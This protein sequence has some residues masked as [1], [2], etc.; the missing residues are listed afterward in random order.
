MFSIQWPANIYEEHLGSVI[1]A[2][3]ILLLFLFF[4]KVFVKALTRLLQRAVG[5][6]EEGLYGVFVRA[7]E[8]PLQVFL[9]F[10][11]LYLC[12]VY[13]PL[14]AAF[15]EKIVGTWRIVVIIFCTWGL[16]NFI[17]YYS[18]YFFQVKNRLDVN[19][20]NILAAFLAKVI[21]GALL[22]LAFVIIVSELGY[23]INGF[24]AGLGL[25]GLTIALA[26]QN[27]AANFFGGV[28]III[29]KPFSIGDWI[30]TPS[31]EGIVE[32]I[33]FR[34][35]KIR[36]HAD[37]LVTVPNATL[38]T[39]A[40]TNWTRMGRRRVKFDLRLVPAT[41]KNKLQKCA[42][43]IKAMLKEHADVHKDALFVRFD[44]FG[45]SSLDLLIYY[46]TAA[47]AF[48]DYL[49]VKEDVNYKIMDILEKEGVDIALPAQIVYLNKPAD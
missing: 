14:S 23:D 20:D 46:F 24:I 28:V 1:V 44:N 21:K 4:R 25:G 34:S 22:L 7:L 10:L 48:D 32:D 47:T 40:V 45:D 2:L 36:T 35:T 8:K 29:D 39:E 38:A 17:G 26:A 6:K 9:L 33:T 12:L 5:S 11:G 13:L 31:V 15:H 30:L 42:R 27:A 18:T 3:S 41:P 43:L 49:R 16:Y 19:I 37:A